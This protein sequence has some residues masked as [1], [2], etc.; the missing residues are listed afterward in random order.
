MRL[1]G[2]KVVRRGLGSNFGLPEGAWT[3][4]GDSGRHLKGCE[5]VLKSLRGMQGCLKTL[6][7]I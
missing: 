5:G 1:E 6:G 2:C 7:G 3:V 4:V